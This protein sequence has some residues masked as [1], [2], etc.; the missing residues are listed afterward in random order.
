MWYLTKLALKNRAVTILL[1]ALLAAASIWGT[2][3]LKREM[4]P[5]IQF[6]YVIVYAVYPDATPGEVEEQVTVPIEHVMWDEW[7]GKGLKHLNS[8][9]ADQICVVFAEFDF[10]TDMEAVNAFLETALG[11]TELDLP[12]A[13]RDF[14]LMNPRVE[15]NP[16][17][18]AM[19][20]SMMPLVAFS[21]TGDVPAEQLGVIA[22]EHVLPELQMVEGIAQAQI[23]GGGR[24]QVLVTL[25]PG[26]MNELGLPMS[27][28]LGLISTIP[29]YGSIG[30]LES[31][32]VGVDGVTLGDVAET[33]VGPAPGTMLSR[34]D[35]EPAAIIVVMKDKDANTVEVANAVRERAEAL[36]LA[37]EE[38]LE[39]SVLFDQSEFIEESISELTRMALIGAALAIV[40]VFLF[41]AAFRASLVT[42]LSIPFSIVIGFL[43]MYFSGITI[44]LLTLSA[45]AI[46]V[47]RLIDNSIVVAEVIYRRMKRGE[48][49]MEASIGGSKE[50]AGPITSS[51]LATV[52]IFIPL[53]FVGGIIGELFL[54]FAL[55]ITFA[56]IASL[57]VALMVV[58]TFSKWF[59]GGKKVVSKESVIDPRNSW[60]QR[61]YVPSLRWAL[62]HRAVTLIVTAV[63][64]F[65]SFALV[66]IIGTSFLPSMTEKMLVVQV[67]LPPGTEVDT[68]S[69]VA[70]LI[71]ALLVDN[72]AVDSYFAMVGTS[73]TSLQSAMSAAFGGGDNTAEIQIMLRDDADE[74]KE[75]SDLEY[76]LEGLMLQDFTTVLSGS[77]AMGSQMG[78]GTGLDISVSGESAEEVSTAT[79][80]LFERLDAMD[81]ILNLETDLSRVVPTLDIELDSEEVVARGLVEQELKQELALLMM[82]ALVDEV[83]VNID[84]DSFGIFVK[85]VVGQL[86]FGEDPVK[87]L[88]LANDL[89]VGGVLSVPLGDLAAVGLPER[90]THVGH[91]DLNLAA[92]I[93]GEI[94]AKDVGAVNRAVEDEIDAVLVEL[95]ELGIDNV[96]I[97]PGGVAE[98]M[99]EYTFKMA[100]AI[101]AAILIVFLILAVSMRSILNPLIIMVSL[102]L[103]SIGALLGLLISG[104]AMGMSGAMGVLMLVGIVLT[105]AIVLIALVEQ[106][107]KEG[108]STYDALVEGGRTRLRP[109]LMTALTTMFA[110]VPLA[111]GVGGGTLIA[112]ELAVVVI[113]GLFSSTLLTL[114]VIPVIYSLADGLR[115]RRR[116]AS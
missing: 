108:T 62:G 87:A 74:S 37:F 31:I 33:V 69:E 65:A 99:A 101:I 51:T 96:E 85:G 27:V 35:G 56:L 83:S 9:S 63:L 47:G 72:E 67:E 109:I 113:G 20:P 94:T 52:A 114:L 22:Q 103:A 95:E 77:E 26:Q 7:E 34:M 54:P 112:G 4:I 10:G 14:P 17:V 40:I 19:D 92:S 39:L 24:D 42:A 89:R 3:Q 97:K 91:I 16:Q 38:T 48:D 29:E 64:F 71:E 102:P 55:T 110:M 86:G 41:L 21:L 49:F 75:Q 25:D 73:T 13:V 90:P 60:Y 6:P 59:V 81:D 15:E 98:E 78:F 18:L 79:A 36:P 111:F 43:A 116:K 70:G 11:S 50:V 104:Y 61:L 30:E 93:T 1:A 46:A 53:I 68:T 88:A 45:M 105:N 82:G 106:L 28:L 5:D 80:L 76:A 23:E 58:P 107:R 2:F 66:P 12:Q 57:V 44:N 100:I 8:T 84:G 115:Q 32:P